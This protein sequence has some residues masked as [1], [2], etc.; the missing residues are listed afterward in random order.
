MSLQLPPRAT[1][2]TLSASLLRLGQL[3][4]GAMAWAAA[5]AVLLLLTS[6]N[7]VKALEDPMLESVLVIGS[8]QGVFERSNHCSTHGSAN[9]P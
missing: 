9:T 1:E 2:F 4:R 5:A 8:E 3:L 6:A 7:A